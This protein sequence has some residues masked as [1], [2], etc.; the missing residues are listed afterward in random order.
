MIQE[1]DERATVYEQPNAADF[2]KV[3]YHAGLDPLLAMT[4]A[5]VYSYR[6][7]QGMNFSDFVLKF[8]MKYGSIGKTCYRSCCCPDSPRRGDNGDPATHLET[9][10]LIWCDYNR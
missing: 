5:D 6:D 1:N 9:R 3:V 8:R 7:F 4:L 10:D 2:N